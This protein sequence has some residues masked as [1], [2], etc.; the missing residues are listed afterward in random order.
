[1]SDFSIIARCRRHGII[2]APDDGE[3]SRC[4]DKRCPRCGEFHDEYHE[5]EE[6]LE[7]DEDEWS[8]VI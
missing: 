8:H 4:S 6:D 7:D 3:C 1:M 2:F 5:C